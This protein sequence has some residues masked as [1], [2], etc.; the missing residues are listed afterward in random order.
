MFIGFVDK[1]YLNTGNGYGAV[2][3]HYLVKKMLD[4]YDDIHFIKSD[5]SYNTTACPIYNTEVIRKEGFIINDTLQTRNN[6]T[7]Y[8][9]EFFNPEYHGE[10]TIT[11]NTHTFHHYAASWWTEEDWIK[12]KSSKRYIRVFGKYI[13]TRLCN[14][15]F[16]Y[17]A[18]G[19]RGIIEKILAK[20][21]R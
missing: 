19:I 16:I 13:G 1:D 4:I 10:I 6:V 5:G 3:H 9:A 11:L 17:K 14:I 2:K 21:R 7:I 20:M 18:S 12:H 15:V 8:P